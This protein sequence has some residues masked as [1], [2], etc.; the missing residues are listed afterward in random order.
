MVVR[1][2]SNGNDANDGSSWGHAKR[3]VQAGIDRASALGGEVWVQAGIYR[4][5]IILHPYVYAYGGFAGTEESLGQRD[6]TSRV[7]VLDGQA[8]GTVVTVMAGEGISTV[9]GFTIRNGRSVSSGGGISCQNSS[10]IIANNAIAGNIAVVDYGGYAGAGIYCGSRSSPMI[11]NNRITGNT[12]SG[13]G[14]GGNGGGGIYC[15]SESSPRIINNT[16][17]GNNSDLPSAAFGSGG[18]ACEVN[19]SPTI[20]NTIVAF[21]TSGIGNWPSS[22]TLTLR[23]NC[24]Y[25]N[26]A[27]NYSSTLA[28]PT[29][30]DGNISADPKLVGL[31]YGDVHIQPD[32]PCK[33]AGDDTQVQEGGRD[34][35][36]Q[37]R[38]QGSHVD[39]GADES[40][41]SVRPAGPYIVVRVGPNGNDANDGSSWALAKRTVQAGI[42]LA[43]AMGGEVWVQAGLYRERIILHP[44]AYV[45]GGFAGTE[46]SRGQRRAATQACILDGEA[47]GSVVS[48]LTGD[49]VSAI[50]GFTIRNGQASDGGGIYCGCGSPTITNNTI[51]DNSS[52]IYCYR[53]SPTITNNTIVGNTV[54]GIHGGSGLP[55]IVNTIVAFNCTG[56]QCLSASV[57]RHNCV[58]GNTVFNYYGPSDPTG[59]DGNISADP[60]LAGA[61]YGNVHI[62]PDSP[63]KDAGDDGQ[64]QADWRDIDGQARIQGSHVD[65]GADESDGTLCPTG[66]YVI[67]RV[68]PNGDDANDGSSWASAKRT[69]QDGV[70]LASRS[71]GDVWVQAGTYQERITLHPY[72][73]VYGGFAGSE[74]SRDQRDWRTRVTVLDGQSRGSV[75]S[76]GMGYL[77]TT[78]DGFTVRNGNADSGGGIIASG[79]GV[80]AND[81]ITGNTASSG[82]GVSGKAAFVVNCTIKENFAGDGIYCSGSTVIAGNV[83]TGNHG[84]GIHCLNST[85]MIANNTIVGNG[86]DGV[87]CDFCA[88]TVVNTIVAFNS[89]GVVC[90]A[91][92]HIL[93]YNCV[94]GNTGGNYYG[95]TDPTGTDGNISVDPK[96]AGASYGN[97][98][99]Q[100]DSPCKDVG[101]DVQVQTDWLDIDGQARIQGSHVDIGADESDGTVSPAGP[102]VIVRVNPN[103]DDANDGSSWGSAKRTVQAGID[104]ANRSGGEVWVQAGTYQERITLHAYVHAYGGFSGTET[105]RDQRD[106]RTQA[107]ILDGQAAGSVVS[108]QT[109]WQAST[110]DGFTIRNGR[111]SNGAGI[112]CSAASPTIAHNTIM[113]NSAS[114]A[115]GGIYCISSSP[116]IADNAVVGSAGSGI[117]CE[118]SS[119]MIANNAIMGN[120]GTGV[121]CGSSSSTLANNTITGNG[122]SGLNCS[123]GSAMVVNNTITG[124]SASYGAG[125]YNSSASLAI[126]NTIVAFNSSGIYTTGSG[127]MILR[128]NCVYGNR[129][130]DYSGL[131]APTG[132]DGNISVDPRLAA[133]AYGNVH[134]QPDSPCKDAGD[135]AMI[136]AGW[137]DIDGRTEFRAATWTSARTSRTA[138]FSRQVPTLLCGSV[139]TVTMPTMGLHGRW[140]RRRYRPVSPWPACWAGTSGS[141]QAPIGNGSRYSRTS[142]SMAVL[143]AQKNRGTSGIGRSMLPSWTARRRAR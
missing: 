42:D 140:R 118:S 135:D 130:Y 68:S 81:V 105:S 28:D 36:G 91:S 51:T 24:V 3:T 142:A 127:T 94:Y 14:F 7:S 104:L 101:D 54:Y 69:V 90:G 107:T 103:G 71:G 123:S 38:I 108:A 115:G 138:M 31:A 112:Y 79:G 50:D 40:D 83:I 56:I 75:V 99:I 77:A 43:G 6:W 78:I 9:D 48:V 76:M 33:D 70:D 62:Q 95:L 134:I 88:P 61:S 5:R 25:G 21:N 12:A 141:R 45:Y 136:Q 49:R 11:I 29:G 57:L 110:I 23:N 131:T 37:A 47:S 109:G 132:I 120:A 82:G 64:V 97:V 52:G 106:W 100:P 22:T 17:T 27:Y 63:C 44:Y 26:T 86:G 125:I 19:S 20:V 87:F 65:I 39:I 89:I 84:D 111:A 74:T 121:F 93:R 129:S 32:S 98:H 139:H 119:P 73:H 8:A 137:Q 18:I 16:I 92:K 53:S 60:K 30:S 85:A 35:D 58:Y 4:E 114:G 143:P 10:P 13:G 34:I 1:V 2:S 41:G 102:Y 72:V 113:G 126:S 117:H 66:P 116:T 96:F 67:V 133:V 55:T 59:T 122:G 46:D 124:N 128:H 15:S 80:I